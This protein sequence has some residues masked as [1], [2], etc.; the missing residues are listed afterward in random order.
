MIQD[1]LIRD[2]ISSFGS[3]LALLAATLVSMGIAGIFKE[4]SGRVRKVCK[5]A[6][7]AFSKYL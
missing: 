2:A 7:K 6:A 1:P 5:K 3:V 4:L